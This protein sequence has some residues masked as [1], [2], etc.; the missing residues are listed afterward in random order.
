MK[1]SAYWQTAILGLIIVLAAVID[2]MKNRK[3]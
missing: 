3:A 1:V 2:R